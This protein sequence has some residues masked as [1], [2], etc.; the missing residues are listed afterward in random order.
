MHFFYDILALLLL[1]IPTFYFPRIEGLWCR[2][3]RR[4]GQQWTGWSGKD[5]WCTTRTGIPCA[6]SR[7]N[8][9]TAGGRENPINYA[10]NYNQPINWS[11]G[12][13]H[14]INQTNKQSPSAR[15]CRHF[16]RLDPKAI[17]MFKDESTNGYY[18]VGEGKESWKG[19]WT[20]MGPQP[21]FNQPTKTIAATANSQRQFRRFRGRR[22]SDFHFV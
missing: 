22:E 4:N 10:I 12:W 14:P 13:S 20:G 15:T 21:D 3:S 5:G 19:C 8:N 9:W 1:A 2:R 11:M 16:W 18:K 6:R 17:T 7:Q